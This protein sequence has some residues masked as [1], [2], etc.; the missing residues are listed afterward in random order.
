VARQKLR[1]RL[2][3]GCLPTDLPIDD[4]IALYQEAGWTYRKP[5]DGSHHKFTKPGKVTAVVSEHSGK[6]QRAAV[7]ALV[8]ALKEAEN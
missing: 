1:E 5:K 6:V 7:R 3:S 4:V 8:K 2:L